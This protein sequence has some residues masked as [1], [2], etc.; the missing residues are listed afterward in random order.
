MDFTSSYM[1][2]SRMAQVSGGYDHCYVLKK[3]TGIEA[4]ALAARVV[5]KKGRTME[6]W[7]TQP[8]VQLYTG[9]F[10]FPMK[11]SSGTTYDKHHGFCLETEAFPDSVNQSNFPSAIL[12]PGQTYSHITVHKFL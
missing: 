9:N 10:L 11:G 7:T 5:G 6:V 3:E 2:G 12:L 8:G 4:L 1:I